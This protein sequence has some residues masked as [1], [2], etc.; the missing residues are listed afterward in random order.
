MWTERLQPL[1]L[2]R[3]RPPSSRPAPRSLRRFRGARRRDRRGRGRAGRAARQHQRR[4]AAGERRDQDR[5]RPHE[6]PGRHAGEDRRREGGDRQAG[7][8][9]R[10]RRASA[11][12][13]RA[14]SAAKAQRAVASAAIPGRAPTCGCSRRTYE[15]RGPLG[16]AGPHQRRNAAVAHGVL[17]G[18]AAALAAGRRGDRS[19]VRRARGF[20]GRLDRRGKWLFDV[21]HN[22][23][24][25]PRAGRGARRAAAASADPRPGLDP[26]RQGVA[27]DAGAARPGDRSRGAHRRADGRQHAAGTSDWLRRWLSDASTARRP[28]PRG[29]WCPTSGRRWQ[30]VQRGAATVLVTGSFH[31]VGDV[32]QALG[33][34]EIC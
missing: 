5:A 7:C 14:C 17:H 8:A 34:L 31:T 33:A 19:R 26:G 15:W 4:A 18:P 3:T 12:A 10:D 24:R 13:G 9:V 20:P 6:V 29:R 27:G 1:I 21:A 11:G 23:G 25:H 2:E 32:M 16:L 28:A 30:V 22:P